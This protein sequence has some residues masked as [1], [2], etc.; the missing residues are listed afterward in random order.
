M[1]TVTERVEALR[2]G[3][4]APLVVAAKFDHLYDIGVT[5]GGELKF[6]CNDVG[7]DFADAFLGGLEA[8][9]S[10]AKAI[11]PLD[12]APKS[13]QILIP[14]GQTTVTFDG[15]PKKNTLYITTYDLTTND[16]M[17]AFPD[18]SRTNGGEL[19]LTYPDVHHHDMMAV[20]VE[21]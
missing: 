14:A 3:Y 9:L 21:L 10:I 11:A 18:Q 2:T 4:D 16:D 17:W 8:G 20:V 6:L 1:K 13:W 15:G 7:E 5:L 19:I 12:S